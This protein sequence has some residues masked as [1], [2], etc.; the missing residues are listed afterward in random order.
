MEGVRGLFIRNL[1][2]RPGKGRRRCRGGWGN[3][4]PQLHGDQ[5]SLWSDKDK[6]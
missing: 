3:D 6:L 4:S 1:D 5:P 2:W